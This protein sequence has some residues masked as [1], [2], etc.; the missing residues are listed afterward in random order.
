MYKVGEAPPPPPHS[1]PHEAKNRLEIDILSVSPAPQNEELAPQLP[2]NKWL[3]SPALPPLLNPL[4]PT[5]T[6]L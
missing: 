2:E 6:M 5:N 1:P 3:F 4:G